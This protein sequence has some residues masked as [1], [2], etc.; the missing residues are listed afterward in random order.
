MTKIEAP[1]DVTLY[2]EVDRIH[3]WIRRANEVLG[4]TDDEEFGSPEMQ[5]L[6]NRVQECLNVLNQSLAVGLERILK[7]L[8]RL[9]D[10][11][12]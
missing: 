8:H 11:V 3:K 7:E 10:L 4:I 9:K 6:G 2:G 12:G 5:S 1:Q